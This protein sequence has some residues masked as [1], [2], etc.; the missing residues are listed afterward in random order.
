MKSW[1]ECRWRGV[2]SSVVIGAAALFVSNTYGGPTVLYAL[3]LGMAFHFISED[4]RAVAGIELCAK[5]FLRIG[6]GLL[7]ARIT[8][9]E[10]AQ[11]SVGS[12]TVLITGVFATVAFS[13]L[14]N[15]WIKWP[16]AEGALAGASV[17]ICGA[18]AAAA[19]ALVIDKKALRE[20]ALLAIIVTVTAL[21]TISMILYPILCELLGFESSRAGLLLGGTIHDVAQVVGA[22]A[23]LGNDALQTATMTK[24]LRVAMLIPMMF[25][26]TALFAAKGEHGEPNGPKT[27]NPFAQIPLFLI[28]FVVLATLNVAGIIP[29]SV[30]D[31]LAQASQLLIL[32]AMGALGI[33]TSLGKLKAVG[34]APII[35]MTLD[36]IFLFV[37]VLAGILLVSCFSSRRLSGA[38]VL[39][40]FRLLL[41]CAAWRFVST[42]RQLDTILKFVGC[43]FVANLSNRRNQSGV[44][45]A[46][47][48]R[49]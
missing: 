16:R 26:F 9:E 35:L 20:Q 14:L 41:K 38:Y 32:V 49:D 7:G 39:R 15:R 37:W 13:M 24:M 17:A 25:V 4:N 34:W 46:F 21:S 43:A 33:K 47:G 6:V 5:N 23:M 11:L 36:T 29:I 48:A 40:S 3:L 8:A 28:G 27:V 45:E 22:G 19:L 1:I 2:L 31:S 12:I 30:S 18:S 44:A 42:S 10:L